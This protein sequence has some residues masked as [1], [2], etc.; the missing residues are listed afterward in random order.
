MEPESSCDVVVIGGG[1]AGMSAA[2]RAAQLGLRVTVLE[3]G[4]A[5]SYPC[6]TRF[7]GGTLHVSYTDVMSGEAVLAGA[8]AAR[9]AG[10]ARPELAQAVAHDAGKAVRW[11]QGEGARFLKI[12]TD[13]YLS[14]KSWVLAPPPRIRPGLDAEGRGSDR[15]LRAFESNLCERGGRIERGVRARALLMDGD[16]CGG[17]EADAASGTVRVHAG[18]TV[19]ADGGFQADPELVRRHISAAPEKLRQRGAAT[20]TG[21]GLRMAV[22]AGAA[23][24]G[25]DCFYGHLLSIDA[26]DNDRLWPYPYLDWVASAG[27]VVD[28]RG[29]RF[30]DEGKGGVFIANHV[31]RLPDPLSAVT[32]FDHRIWTEGAGR[33]ALVP[34]NPHIADAGGTIHQAADLASLAGLIGVPADALEATV[35]S[36]NAALAGGT[37]PALV[38]PRSQG[39]KYVPAPIATPPYYAAPMCAGI[40]FTMG[41]ISTDAFARVLDG[42]RRPIPGL[43][44]AGAATGGLEGGPAIGYVGGLIKSCVFG[45]R[46]AETIAAERVP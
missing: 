38:P 2:C 36:Y 40:T 33:A 39:G 27:V 4:T 6:N 42:E 41:G 31:A 7:S 21:D 11:L 1:M 35:G 10:F 22:A 9:T 14:Y 20:G 17:V 29:M 34:A 13:A 3:K 26:F 5:E 16:R 44:A 25:M 32:I 19:I 46:A 45:L 23:V 8:I 15:L 43:F 37:L 18:A 24:E 28:G 30:V 12:P